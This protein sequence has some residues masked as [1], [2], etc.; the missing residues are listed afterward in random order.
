[1]FEYYYQEDKEMYRIPGVVVD[2]IF[3]KSIEIISSLLLVM[4]V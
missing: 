2:L 4:D 3:G 1:L